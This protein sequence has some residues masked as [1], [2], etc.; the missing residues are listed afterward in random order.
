MALGGVLAALAVT[1]MSLGGLIPLA[2]YVCP[3]IAIL[4][5][6]VVLETCGARVAWAWFGAVAI[7]SLLLGPDKEAAAVFVFLGYYPILKPKLDT[8]KLSWLWKGLLF[9]TSVLLM[10]WL[11]IHLFG[12][13]Q[14]AYEFRELGTLMLA[15]TLLLGNV[16][17][18]LVDHLL[19]KKLRFRR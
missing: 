6:K 11:L 16:C 15:V 19:N 5:L 1:V 7:L 18:V 10:Y 9:N 12:M 13:A 2:T 17:F 3:M 8:T 4:L 14:L